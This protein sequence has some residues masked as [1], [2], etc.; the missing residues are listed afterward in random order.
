[1]LEYFLGVMMAG[2]LG[3]KLLVFDTRPRPR[4]RMGPRIGN[5]G[6]SLMT[7]RFATGL[8]KGS[9]LGSSSELPCF[10]YE[11]RT[12]KGTKKNI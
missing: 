4:P 3:T 12:C 2:I 9:L 11:C 8:A 6:I 5:F 7:F 1:M 10:P